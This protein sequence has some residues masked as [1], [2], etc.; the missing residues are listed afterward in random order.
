[1]SDSPRPNSPVLARP[2]MPIALPLP[3]SRRS[4]SPVS[5]RPDTLFDSESRS[6]SPELPRGEGRGLRARGRATRGQ[7]ARRRRGHDSPA[8]SSALDT[9]PTSHVSTPSVRRSS[10]GHDACP[11][12]Y[13]SKD[14]PTALRWP[15]QDPFT[16]EV[17]P[18]SPL[19][20]TATALDFFL[21][22]FDHDL[23]Q[24]IVTQTNLY[25]TTREGHRAEWKDLTVPELQS[26]L[27]TILLMGVHVLPTIESYWSTNTYLGASNVVSSFPRDR[28]TQILRELHFNDNSTAVE[29]GQPGYDRGH[30]IRPVVDSILEK[31]LSLYKPHR[32]NSVD[33]AMVKYKGRSQLKQYMPMKPIKRGFKVWC[34]C[35]AHSGFTCCFQVYLGAT[36]SAEKN[37]GVRVTM[38]M[39]RDIFGKGYHLYC[40]NFFTCPQL[41][42]QLLKEKVYCIG[43]VKK[44]RRGFTNFNDN[45][46]KSLKKGEDISNV[47]FLSL[48]D[49]LSTV[50]PPAGASVNDAGP[51]DEAVPT[52]NSGVVVPSSGEVVP[53][54][55][56]VVVPSS[57][58]V[59]AVSSEIVV[60]SSPSSSDPS[61]YPVHC[62]C[63]QDKKPVFFVNTVTNPRTVT[64]VRR[65]QKDGS[66][67]NYSCPEAV[68]LY[69]KY[70]GGVDMADA[71]RRVYTCTRKSKHK[72]YM[73]LFW[74]LL[75]TCVVN[76]YI[77]QKESPNHTKRISHLNFVVELAQQLI[78]Q[79]DSRGNVGRPPLVPCSDAR[80]TKHVPC[81]YPTP[82]ACKVCSNNK[83]RSRTM[84]GCEECGLAFCMPECY[85]TYHSRR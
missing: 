79:N 56:E 20:A 71:M 22:L 76:A 31:C 77:L 12:Y 62:F 52:A 21:Q 46:I 48:E 8:S 81:K 18:T 34:R 55:G 35:D 82:R 30:E 83:R 60:P 41:A 38:D 2:D 19:P 15:V 45:Q 9:T 11:I 66:T 32:E 67:I 49:T 39:A 80:Y 54:S 33:E 36:E 61:H 13:P 4:E 16:E 84:F 53:S 27:G 40:D 58:D 65:K 57:S 64:S 47:E 5:V 42:I 28:F 51:M 63:W 73:R 37:L 69:N 6:V 25:A 3:V 70:M 50:H 74:F 23:L 72:W 17:G 68:S 85:A 75:D 59:P 24:H 10:R 14:T 44:N 29:R 43:T 78:E 1:M 26:F 7:A